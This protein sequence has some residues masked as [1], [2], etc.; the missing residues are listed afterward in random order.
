LID[1]FILKDVLFEDLK[2]H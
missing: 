2:I 1:W